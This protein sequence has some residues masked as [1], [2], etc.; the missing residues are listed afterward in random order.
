MKLKH[1]HM[2]KPLEQQR[3]DEWFDRNLGWVIPVGFLTIC[4]SVVGLILW[5]VPA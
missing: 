3:K 1:K 4:C 2:I 5:L